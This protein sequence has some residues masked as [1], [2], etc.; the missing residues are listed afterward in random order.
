MVHQSQTGFVKGRYAA[1]NIIKIMEIIQQSD[2][3][4]QDNLIISYDFEKAFNTLEWSAIYA[5]LAAMNFGLKFIDMM[6]ILFTNKLITASNNGYW[7]PTCRCRQGCTFS[8]SIFCNNNR[9]SR[10]HNQTKPG[11]NRC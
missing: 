10:H 2:A 4:K 9:N 3:N 7:A 1:E 8:L 6:K 11:Y 5:T